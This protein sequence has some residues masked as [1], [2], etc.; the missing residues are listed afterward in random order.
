[1]LLARIHCSVGVDGENT[2]GLWTGQRGV[3]LRL[4]DKGVI[5]IDIHRLYILSISFLSR[6]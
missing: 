4:D 2:R 3:S 1:M 6:S 5:T